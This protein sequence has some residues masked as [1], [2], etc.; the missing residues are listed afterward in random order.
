MGFERY[1]LPENMKQLLNI[2]I[3]EF[4]YGLMKKK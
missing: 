2:E 4:I 1:Y 3:R